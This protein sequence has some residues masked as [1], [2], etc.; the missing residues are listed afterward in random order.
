MKKDGLATWTG[1][2]LIRST[3]SNDHLG[4]IPPSAPRIRLHQS[5]DGDEWRLQNA[6]IETGVYTGTALPTAGTGTQQDNKVRVSVK[7]MSSGHSAFFLARARTLDREGSAALPGWMRTRGRDGRSW[8]THRRSGRVTAWFSKSMEK[9]RGWKGPG[10]HAAACK[11]GSQ[12]ANC[13]MTEWILLWAQRAGGHPHCPCSFWWNITGE[14]LSAKRSGGLPDLLHYTIRDRQPLWSRKES[15]IP[16]VPPTK[17]WSFGGESGVI[18]LPDGFFTPTAHSMET[19]VV[20]ETP[21]GRLVWT[22]FGWWWACPSPYSPR[23]PLRSLGTV[24]AD[25]YRDL[26]MWGSRRTK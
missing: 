16:K 18:F 9:Y 19:F 26:A 23:N 21:E 1:D 4:N 20:N 17:T 8:Q 12:R 10:G 13:S 15:A 24:G 3:L 25:G 14:R 7:E 11:P 2:L 22:T 5:I 6:V